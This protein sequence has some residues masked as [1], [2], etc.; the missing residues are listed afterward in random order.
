MRLRD[1]IS[2][3]FVDKWDTSGEL[4][5]RPVTATRIALV[6]G[7]AHDL[8]VAVAVISGAFLHA[9]VEQPFHGNRQSITENLELCGK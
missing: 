5:S 2:S 1:V 6:L 3:Q 4:R 7:L 9:A 8:D